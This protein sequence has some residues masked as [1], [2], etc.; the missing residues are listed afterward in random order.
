MSLRDADKARQAVNGFLDSLDGRPLDVRRSLPDEEKLKTAEGDAVAFW[1]INSINFRGTEDG[2]EFERKRKEGLDRLLKNARTKRTSYLSCIRLAEL[3]G[4]YELAIPVEL[5]NFIVAVMREEI[6][7]PTKR[8]AMVPGR[9][10]QKMAIVGCMRIAHEH[11]N[12]P[13]YGESSRSISSA[14]IVRDS[15]DSHG[16]KN[17][18]GKPYSAEAIKKLYQRSQS[19]NP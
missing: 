1:T 13:L 19:N 10:M 18:S 3:L 11:M 4:E 15:L 7:P 12:M 2:E 8:G 17:E 16:Y 9:L 14:E 6:K 5:T